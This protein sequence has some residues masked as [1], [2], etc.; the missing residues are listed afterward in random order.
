MT[1]QVYS[2]TLVPD[3]LLDHA[4]GRLYATPLAAGTA[5][6]VAMAANKLYSVPFLV[7][8]P[9][10]YTVI[11]L[12]M[13]S[14]TAGNFRLG[15]YN[16]GGSDAPGTLKLDAGAVALGSAAGFKSIAISQLLNPGWYHLAVVSDAAP[17][18]RASTAANCLQWRGFTSGTD[19]TT[20]LI[21]SVAFTYAALPDPFTGGGALEAIAI[22]RLMMGA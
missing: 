4:S 16:D 8:K 1:I 9:T 13:T 10:T 20:K 5:T 6:T 19:V 3:L 21:Y 7:W 14:A 2:Q 17:T 11:G 15:I 22:L 18:V 12:E